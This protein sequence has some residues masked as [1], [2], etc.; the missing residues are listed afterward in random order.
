MMFVN[1]VQGYRALWTHLMQI[2]FYRLKQRNKDLFQFTEP[3]N[4]NAN[5]NQDIKTFRRILK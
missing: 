2:Q 3:Y 1:P 4:V 5:H